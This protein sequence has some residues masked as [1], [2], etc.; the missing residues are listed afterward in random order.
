MAKS[1]LVIMAR[2]PEVGKTKTRLAR[3]LGDEPTTELYR[4][5]L[6]DLA[7]RFRGQ[8]YDLLWAYTPPEVDYSHFIASLYENPQAEVHC[9]PQ[10]G[11]ALGARLHNVF[12]HTRSANYE[13]TVVISSDS[14]QISH[15]LITEAIEALDNSDLVLGPAEDGGYYLIAMRHPHDVFTGV[16]MSTAVVLHKTLMLA[17]QQ[18]LSTTQLTPLFDVDEFPDLLRL[19]RLLKHDSSLAPATARQL[20]LT[21][22]LYDDNTIPADS[23]TL[24][25]Y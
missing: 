21:R 11:A 4:A 13:K 8:S 22:Y 15:T 18:G 9:I 20:A 14:P 24:D 10:Q 25:L 1:A 23:A 6:T 17:Q 3:H 16:P 7:Q 12:R 19:A 2:Y 5:F